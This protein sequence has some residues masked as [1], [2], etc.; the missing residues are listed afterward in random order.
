MKDLHFKISLDIF[1]LML[2]LVMKPYVV[3]IPL[4]NMVLWHCKIKRFS[5]PKTLKANVP[6][7]GQVNPKNIVLST[8]PFDWSWPVFCYK[9]K[10]FG[11]PIDYF[12][13]VVS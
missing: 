11:G 9:G 3:D 10:S 6:G 12:L 7:V 4:N 8:H 13:F 1:K 2:R 5:T